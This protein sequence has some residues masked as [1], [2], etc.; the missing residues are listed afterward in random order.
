MKLLLVLALATL[1]GAGVRH[2]K[3][4]ANSTPAAKAH[5]APVPGKVSTPKPAL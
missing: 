1:L 2:S 5:T 3:A 4:T